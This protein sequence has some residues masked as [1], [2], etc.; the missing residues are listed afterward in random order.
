MIDLEFKIKKFGAKPK[1]WKF[2]ET[3][4]QPVNEEELKDDEKMMKY[5]IEY[6]IPVEYHQEDKIVVDIIGNFTEWLPRPIELSDPQSHKYSYTG[7]FRRGFKHR[8]QF[9]VNGNEHI[10]E[11]KKSSVNVT[12]SK[13]NYIMIPLK[14]FE[15][16]HAGDLSSF[17]C[18]DTDTPALLE[19]PSFVP[20]EMAKVFSK[21]SNP[22]DEALNTNLNE[23]VFNKMKHCKDIFEKKEYL[24]KKILE[25]EQE[26]DRTIFRSQYKDLDADYWRV[27]IALKKAVQGRIVHTDGI[28]M[29]LF[30]VIE[31]TSHDNA[32]RVKRLY[33]PNRILLEE[34]TNP[35]II[36][37]TLNKIQQLKFLTLQ[38]E[39][40]VRME[41]LKDYHTFKIHYQ[42]ERIEGE[43][44]CLP[45]SIEP[46]FINMN[47]YTINF[48]RLQSQILSI[49]HNDS[50]NIKFIAKEID[51]TAGFIQNSVFEVWT[52]EVNEKV[53]NIIHCHINDMSD[54]VP[55]ATE[56]LAE[57]ESI[58]DY[59]NFDT[60]SAGQVLRYKI[61]I[62]NRR[63]LTVLYNSGASIE[64]I[65]FKEIKLSLE[66]PLIEARAPDSGDEPGYW[67]SKFISDKFL[68]KWK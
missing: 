60:D 37:Y 32:L 47:D 52:N 34:G 6:D 63:I 7:Y 15:D 61:L 50:G 9:L 14:S 31:Y 39:A 3:K 62:Q 22:D 11:N 54:S 57:G 24:E 20:K 25:T 68:I 29:S 48:D 44:E 49:R 4:V 1:S 21:E 46:S 35:R 2:E 12:G 58:Q 66:E 43:A 28:N 19:L 67:I 42:V 27:G 16:L 33:D 64:E 56:Y 36:I 17:M 55:I 10:D 38:Q 53:Y 59:M 65:P 41:M 18:Q 26:K 8:Y 23:Y 13:T 40:S 5:T 45:M 51:S 30:E